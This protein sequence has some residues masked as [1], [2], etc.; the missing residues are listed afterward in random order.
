[1]K[2]FHRSVVLAVV[3]LW[4]TAVFAGNTAVVPV[5]RSFPTNWMSLHESFIAR[6]KQGHIDLLF[7][8]DSIT[9]GWLWGNGGL[10]VWNKYYV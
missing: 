9:A 2:N 8:G 4:A 10:N 7:L 3:A 6:A 5:P 1:M